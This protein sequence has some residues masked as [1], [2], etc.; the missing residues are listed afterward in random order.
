M[1][2]PPNS[3]LGSH[4]AWR[5]PT[6]PPPRLGPRFRQ[7]LGFHDSSMKLTPRGP[8]F[9]TGPKKKAGDVKKKTQPKKMDEHLPKAAAFERL[10]V[11]IGHH[12]L[13]DSDIN[14]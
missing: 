13:D 7:D 8:N 6:N 11:G 3:A 1:L 4:T 2:P 5:K 12:W 9:R 14:D 10:F